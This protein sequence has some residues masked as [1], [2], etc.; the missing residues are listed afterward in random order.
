MV[1]PGRTP[2]V[3]RTRYETIVDEESTLEFQIL[4]HALKLIE[5]WWQKTE[6]TRSI[7]RD[8]ADGFSFDRLEH[9]VIDGGH[10]AEQYLR[11][12]QKKHAKEQA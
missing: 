4:C 10:V 7:G 11:V 5:C 12:A 6:Q 8:P 2:H 1:T 9:A 3:R